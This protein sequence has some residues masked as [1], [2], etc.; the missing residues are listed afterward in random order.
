[1]IK[2]DA[3]KQDIINQAQRLFQQY[4]L[5]KTTMDEIAAA[6]G[7]AKSTMYHYFKN[8]D[9]VFDEVIHNELQN[10]RIIVQQNVD[11]KTTLI[12]KL[13]VYFFVFH[14]ETVQ[15]FNLFR[16]LKQE[17]KSEIEKSNRFD[18][19][20]EFEKN[21]IGGLITDG[22][23][24]EEFSGIVKE[25]IP[26]FSEIILVAF[27]GIVR[28]SIEKEGIYNEGQLTKVIDVLIPRIFTR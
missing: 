28:H 13:K 18:V 2:D 16:I 17:L 1:M 22:Y 5:K 23:E 21:F 4:G 12:E 6:C 26:W 20:I 11:Q 10:I 9:E 7:K 3:V 8:K 14:K 27:L 25:D 15:N 24:N 19:A